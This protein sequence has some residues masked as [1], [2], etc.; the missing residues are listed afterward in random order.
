MIFTEIRELPLADIQRYHS[1]IDGTTKWPSSWPDRYE[2]IEVLSVDFGGGWEMDINIC[3]GEPT[4]Y[5]DA[6]LFHDGCEVYAWE[7]S[8]TLVGEWQVVLGDDINRAF[9]LDIR[10]EESA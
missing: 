10:A 2:T 1:I 3:H 6:V 9:R 8:E 4:P 5:V 7:I